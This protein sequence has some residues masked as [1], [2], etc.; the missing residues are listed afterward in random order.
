MHSLLLVFLC[1]AALSMAPPDIIPGDM[2]FLLDVVAALGV[3]LAADLGF[4]AWARYRLLS[5]FR[6]AATR[7]YEARPGFWKRLLRGP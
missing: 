1:V 4:G 7:R 5:E 2:D 3:G 6:L